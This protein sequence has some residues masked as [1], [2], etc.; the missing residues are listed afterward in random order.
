MTML[1]DHGRVGE[2]APMSLGVLAR[3]APAAWRVERGTI[4]DFRAAWL[5]CHGLS[6]GSEA[7][8]LLCRVRRAASSAEF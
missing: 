2:E 7:L 5:R 3:R 6:V 8:G 1:L 4:G